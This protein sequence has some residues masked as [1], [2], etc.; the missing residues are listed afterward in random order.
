MSDFCEFGF[1]EEQAV[2]EYEYTEEEEL[3]LTLEA[4]LEYLLRSNL[5]VAVNKTNNTRMVVE[6]NTQWY[7]DFCG[8]YKSVCY[9]YRNSKKTKRMKRP[10]TFIK[11]CCTIAALKRMIKG[12][13]KGEYAARILEF[14]EVFWEKYAPGY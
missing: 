11:R 2:V 9:V 10:R 7:Q 13:L 3:T 12:N 6:Y 5:Q 8:S 14:A 1:G 4:M